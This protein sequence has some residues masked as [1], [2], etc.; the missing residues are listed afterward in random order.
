MFGK[1]S[2]KWH[3]EWELTD[4]LDTNYTTTLIRRYMVF[5]EMRT[6]IYLF[7]TFFVIMELDLSSPSPQVITSASCPKSLLL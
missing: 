5:I 7:L 4:L 6:T 3:C 2:S 1:D